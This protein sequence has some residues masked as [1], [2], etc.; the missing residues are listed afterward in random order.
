MTP[1][2]MRT[3]RS[4]NPA[5]AE[6]ARA[7]VA[8]VESLFMPWNVEALVAGFTDDC[9][10][11]FGVIPEFRGHE[12]LRR[13]FAARSARQKDYRLHKEFR[14]LMGDLVTNVWRGEW[15]DAETEQ[16]MKGFGIEVWKMRD[17]KIALWEAS[18][19]AAPADQAIDV[20]RALR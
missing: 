2:T 5:T 10:V 7:L 16:R 11:R 15:I 4:G 18:F 20:E 14:S 19:N 17:G 3:P 8:Q 13:F 1:Q 12:A 6:E 9:I